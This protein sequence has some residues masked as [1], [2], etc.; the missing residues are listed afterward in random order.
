MGDVIKANDK[1]SSSKNT[2]TTEEKLKAAYAL[3]MCTV[4]VSQIV[5]YNDSYILEQEYDAI[6]NNLNL[7]EMP[8]D[9]ALLRIIT[10]L[11][12]TI[13]FFRIQE[14]KKQQIEKKYNQ[15]IKNALWSAVPSLSV[16]VSGNPVAIAMSLATQIGT[17]Y[18]NYR[19]EKNSALSDREDSEIELEITAIEQ[20]NS[21]KRELF[22]T[23][24]R[25]A[26]EYD[27]ED[28]WRITEKQIKQYNEILMDPDELRKYA[29][30]EAIADRFIAYPPFWYFYGHTANYISEMAKNRIALNQRES[31]EA[32]LAYCKD[33]ALVKRYSA[34]AKAHYDH[35]YE[36]CKNN[37][38]REDQLTASFAL[39]YVDLL[40]G[41]GEKEVDKMK[42]LVR[43]AEKMAPTS[44]DVIQ[45][46]VISYLKL[47]ETDDAARLLKILV[48]EDYNSSANAKL[49]SRIYVSKYLFG[50]K[51]DAENAM[52]E[53]QVL[54]DMSDSVYL[55]PMPL[56]KPS[57]AALE[58][59]ELEGRYIEEQKS[60]LRK[61][62]R[63]AINEFIKF[64][65]KKYNQLWPIPN[66]AKKV[67]D[68]YFDYT[69]EAQNR[70]CNDVE[71]AL[72]GDDRHEYVNA[73]RD[74]SYR[75]RYLDLLNDV[76][77]AL[78]ELAIFRY[79]EDKDYLI[80]KIRKGIVNARP[81]LKKYQEKLEN[82]SF[83]FEDFLMLQG[84]LS[85]RT[86][87]EEFF[88]ELKTAIMNQ[89][90]DAEKVATTMGETPMKYLETAEL[91]LIEFCR[92]HNL[93]DPDELRKD[94]NGVIDIPSC[95][96]YFD[97][98]ILG[99]DIE[100]EVDRNEQ[101]KEMQKIV[102]DSVQSLRAG[103]S[104]DIAIW[105]PESKEFEAYFKN[106]K[107]GGAGLKAIVLAII[108]DKS[109]RDHDLLL[110]YNGII[111]VEKNRIQPVVDY[112]KV[113]YS[114]IGKRDELVID[115]PDTYVNKNINITALYSLIEQLSDIRELS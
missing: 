59:R 113:R 17:G 41:E 57:D 83:S 16:V 45:L 105:L 81:D 104:D 70:R 74:S 112:K 88:D 22:T 42:S 20:L 97:Y 7:K 67:D 87:T 39:E 11:L 77:R 4:S 84:T 37:I 110:T 14:I 90:D 99:D 78:D 102:R 58:D 114:K 53:Y 94:N 73:L 71:K 48:N 44:L 1:R 108:D 38:L 64:G 47:G 72:D 101:R 96:Y 18:M 66:T 100:G 24:W 106:V 31:E 61:D 111:I 85:F 95:N 115:W 43:L 56:K 26:D 15:R 30:L 65:M 3:N 2:H 28:E 52:A 10:E 35:Y 63:V 93:P 62:Y 76:L 92:N 19:K 27:F 36:L 109:K 82:G 25:L 91:D 75:I 34:L 29:R 55:F 51:K 12:N 98:S 103:N 69:V 6:L 33:Q 60:L 21:L 23:A 13:T 80:R 50:N 49:L 54:S 8:K 5:D 68:S 86:F 89:I 79:Y 32:V 9:E 46:C 107:L 40:F